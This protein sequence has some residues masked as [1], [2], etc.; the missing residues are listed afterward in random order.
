M[1]A[2]Y[3]NDV[4]DH[5]SFQRI[6][7]SQFYLKYKLMGVLLIGRVPIPMSCRCS[8]RADPIT[9]PMTLGSVVKLVGS[10]E[11]GAKMLSRL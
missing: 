10:W 4:S 8:T 3:Q 9:D 2:E 5:A 1:M 6:I 11:K 7:V